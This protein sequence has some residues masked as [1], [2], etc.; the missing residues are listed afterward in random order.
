MKEAER[1]TGILSSCIGQVALR[2]SQCAGGYLWRFS[3]D[4]TPD[5]IVK[6][7]APSNAN[8][9][10]CQY[11]L[12]GQLISRFESLSQA[13]RETECI[14][15]DICCCCKGKKKTAGGYIWKYTDDDTPIAPQPIPFRK[16]V[17][18]Q[19]DVNRQLIREWESA[20]EAAKELGLN[21]K[22]IIRCCNGRQISTGGYIWSYAD[23]KGK[24]NAL[25]IPSRKKPVLQFDLNGNL[26]KEWPSATDAGKALGFSNTLISNCC[27]GGKT[28]MGFKWRFKEQ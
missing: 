27:R 14:S 10:V 20:T 17:V 18:L 25:I 4:Y 28:S 2:R 24:I 5:E 9:G 22:T 8:R 12:S 3:D 16:R 23:E 11:S 26:I 21:P 1:V 15:S 6:Y 19:F 7:E 13:A